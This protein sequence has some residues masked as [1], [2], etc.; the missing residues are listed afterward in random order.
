MTRKIIATALCLA[1]ALCL[2]GQGALARTLRSPKAGR[3]GVIVTEDG[4]CAK[5]RATPAPA[6]TQ[7]PAANA[8]TRSESLAD[9]VVREVNAERAKAGLSSLRVDAELTRAACVR[10]AEIVQVFSH[11][12]P[13]GTAWSTVSKSVYGENIAMGQRTAEKVMAAWMT[14]A[15]H[16]ENILRASFGSIGVCAWT[17]NGVTYWAQLFGK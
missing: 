1:L 5:A 4:G 6:A 8:G 3:E 11:T 2:A 16:R 7:A 10:A 9:Q 14:S 13:D 17:V 15:G 12:R